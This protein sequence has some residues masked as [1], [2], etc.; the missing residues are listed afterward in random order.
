M[1]REGF[2]GDIK[3][4]TKAWKTAKIWI[5]GERWCWRGGILGRRHSLNKEEEG[6][7]EPVQGFEQGIGQRDPSCKA[8]ESTTRHTALSQAL[9]TSN[10]RLKCLPFIL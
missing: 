10:A 1:V 6:G 9:R 4:V 8:V 2:R 5:P 3:L 7:A